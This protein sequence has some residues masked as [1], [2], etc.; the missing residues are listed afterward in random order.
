MPRRDIVPVSAWFAKINHAAFGNPCLL[1][2]GGIWLA[3]GVLEFLT[4]R[5]VQFLFDALLRVPRV[6]PIARFGVGLLLIVGALKDE[7]RNVLLIA[8]GLLS[9]LAGALGLLL[10]ADKLAAYVYWLR[11]RPTLTFRIAGAVNIGLALFI[12]ERALY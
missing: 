3:L 1:V 4:P 11:R 6:M 9:E 10:P 2:A 7:E 5:L 8:L 12:L